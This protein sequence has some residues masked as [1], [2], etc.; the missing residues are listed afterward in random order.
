MKVENDGDLDEHLTYIS[1]M[2]ES[3]SIASGSSCLL[4]VTY[5]DGHT[6]DGR[7]DAQILRY[8]SIV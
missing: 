8:R 7:M 6:F 3:K 5:R 4:L 1:K 2:H